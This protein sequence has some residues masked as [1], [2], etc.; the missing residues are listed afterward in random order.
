MID[1]IYIDGDT[2]LSDTGRYPLEYLSELSKVN[3]FIGANNS[4]KSRLMRELVRGD[5][6]IPLSNNYVEAEQ[7]N[8]IAVWQHQILN[9]FKN[10][11]GEIDVSSLSEDMEPVEF[12]IRFRE[13]EQEELGIVDFAGESMNRIFRLA[14]SMS[15]NRSYHQLQLNEL[16]ATYIPVLRGVEKFDEYYDVTETRNLDEAPLN[17][18]QRK[19]LDSLKEQVSSIYKN[20]IQK[21]YSIKPERIYTGEELFNKITNALLGSEEQRLM[22]RE[23]EDFISKEFCDSKGFSIIPRKDKKFL[24][25]KIGKNKSRALHDLGDGI[26]Q[27][28]TIL[29]E[30]FER[31]GKEWLF[32]IE[33][34]ELNLHPGYQRKLLDLL[35]HYEGFQK[36]QF[37]ITTHSNHFVDGYFMS[38]DISIYKFISTNERDK[39]IVAKT[40]PRDIDVLNLLGVSN[41]SVF[42]SNCSIWVEGL[43]DKIIISKY[44]EVYFEK[45]GLNYREGIDYTFVEYDGDNIDHWDFSSEENTERINVSGITNRYMYICDN[46]DDAKRKRKRKKGLKSILGDNYYELTVREI[47]NTVSLKVLERLLFPEGSPEYKNGPVKEGDYANKKTYMGGFIDDHYVLNRHYSKSGTTARTISDKIGFAR[48]VANNI[49]EYNDLSIRAKNL[50]RKISNFIQ[51]SSYIISTET[52]K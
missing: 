4:G 29:Y 8:N 41:S 14:S 16:D 43:S 33:E 48:M 42:M 35:L 13:I 5:R 52:D 15:R 23:F 47:E 27:L 6:R 37:F 21:V 31:K 50:C 51:R 12:F 45:Y 24:E 28:V 9:Q 3:I 46:D 7:K 19:E 11:Y 30:I 10:K 39:F 44:L 34:P 1:A 32:F 40:T 36:H 17:G 38:E 18:K 2:Y 22:V 25:V 20:K 49:K 26:K